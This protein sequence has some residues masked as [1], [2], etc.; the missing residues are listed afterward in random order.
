MQNVV[1]L[2]STGSVGKTALEVIEAFP[3]AFRVSGLM[4]NSSVTELARQALAHRPPRVSA[5]DPDALG[6][7]RDLLHD[8]GI[9][10]LSSEE[11]LDAMVSAPDTDIVLNAIVGIAGLAPAL[12]ALRAGKTLAVANKEPLVAA[13]PI[14]SRTAEETGARIL[15][16]DSEHSAIFQALRA[17]RRSEVRRILL[18]ASGGPFRDRPLESFEEITPEEALQHPTWSMG[19]KIT[20]DS[21]TMMNKALEVIEAV[22]LFCVPPDRIQVLVHPQSVVHSMVE[23]HDGS[24]IAQMGRPDMHLPVLFALSHP[25]RLPYDRVQ[26]R[27]E[28][29]RELHFDDPDPERY[30]A[31]SLGHRAAREGGVAGA[32]L[33]AANERAVTA[34][35]DGEIPFTEIAKLAEHALDRHEKKR[36]PELADVLEAD[37]WGRLEVERC[38]K[39]T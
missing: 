21:A 33:N 5:N 35:L 39:R 30:P 23:F 11:A 38:L 17:G 16:V 34:F 12:A 8:T 4:A 19:P 18:T 28:D 15:P 3:D 10:V 25:D 36:D 6:A 32:V 37:R 26:F 31:L 20:I 14:L 29:F 9:E 2:G 13:G 24:V 1:V 7:L 27:I 22:S